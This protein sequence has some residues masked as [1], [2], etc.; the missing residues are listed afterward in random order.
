MSISHVALW[1]NDIER[2][3]RFYGTY[4]GAQPSPH[5]SNPAKG[6][7]SCFLLFGHGA[8]LEIMKND[9]AV[10]LDPYTGHPIVG[11]YTSRH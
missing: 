3:K 5:Y 7:E 8:R 11:A 1:T 4:F 9:L 2:I 10:A 6:F